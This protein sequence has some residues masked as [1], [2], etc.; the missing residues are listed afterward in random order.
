MK[1]TI[2]T[3]ILA[4]MLLLTTQII[5]AQTVMQ[6]SGMDCNGVSH[7]LYADLD[8]GKAVLL[9]F[10]MPSCGS[11]PPPALKIQAMAN[12]INATYPGMVKGYAFPFQNSTTCS[13]TSTWCSS[14]GL[15][16]YAPFDSGA[17]QVAHYGG[18]GMPTVVLLGGSGAN[19]R[20]MYSSLNFVTSDTTKM[21]DSIMSLLNPTGIADLPNSVSK[22]N[23]YP[24]PASDITTINLE[25]NESSKL[26]IDVADITGKQVAIIADEKQS[27]GNL[28][29][30]FSTAILPNGNYL[31]RINVN[32]K[33]AT[34]KLSVAH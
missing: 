10:F 32:G 14:N 12:H 1:K 11:C 26:L 13:Y 18:F 22:I 2:T 28:I 24:N 17:A 8:A 3:T 15:T 25:L 16:L 29:K 21:R 7:D 9:H 31:V 30:Q 20:V 4:V 5:K 27:T 33:T 23:V 19:K 6:L 34:Q